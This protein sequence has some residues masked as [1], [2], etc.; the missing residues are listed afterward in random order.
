MIY[1]LHMGLESGQNE[2]TKNPRLAAQVPLILVAAGLD[3]KETDITKRR[4]AAQAWIE[5]G[6]AKVFGDYMDAHPDE[7]LDPNDTE[8]LSALWEK[9]KPTIH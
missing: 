8:A 4:Q 6:N 2:K 1:F 7:T 5:S 3:V 9:I